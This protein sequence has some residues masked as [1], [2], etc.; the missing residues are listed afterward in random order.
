MYGVGGGGFFFPGE[1]AG[2]MDADVANEF[3]VTV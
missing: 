1:R 2:Y 3:G